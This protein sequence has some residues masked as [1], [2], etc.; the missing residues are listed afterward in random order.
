VV[1]ALAEVEEKRPGLERN[2]GVACTFVSAR[3]AFDAVHA[4]SAAGL[5]RVWLGFFQS[6]SHDEAEAVLDSEWEGDPSATSGVYLLRHGRQRSLHE[7]LKVRGLTDFE[8]GCFKRAA[9]PEGIVV[10]VEP[11]GRSEEAEALLAGCGGRLAA[12]QR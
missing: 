12:T 6:A 7:A 8:I 9:P 5:T 1:H 2:R 3:R 11:D 4:L 10:I